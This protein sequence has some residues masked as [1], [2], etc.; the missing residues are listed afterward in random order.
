LTTWDSGFKHANIVL[1]GGALTAT[2]VGGVPQLVRSTTSKS[3]GKVWVEIT[4]STIR[5]DMAVGLCNGTETTAPSAG[6]GGD[7]NSYGFYPVTPPQASYVALTSLNGGTFSSGSSEHVFL[8]IDFG[9]SPPQVWV[10]TETMRAVGNTYNNSTTADPA[11]AT[12][13]QALTGINAGPYF[14]AF[15]DEDGGAQ[16]VA[17]FGATTPAHAIPSGFSAWDPLAPSV[18]T[19]GGTSSGAGIGSGAVA[20]IGTGGGQGSGAGLSVSAGIIYSTGTGGGT[21]TGQALS[22]R[23]SATVG[24][25]G[26]HATGTAFSIVQIGIP[27]YSVVPGSS[28]PGA[29]LVTA[30][31]T[32]RN[33]VRPQTWNASIRAGDDFKVALTVMSDDATPAAVGASTSALG[34]W[35]SDGGWSNGWSFPHSARQ[36]VS[37]W[38]VYGQT[39]RI[40]FALP[41]TE[42]AKLACGRYCLGITVSLPDGSWVV[43]EGMLQ[44]R[45]RWL[46]SLGH[47][48]NSA[49]VAAL[50][51]GQVN[52]QPVDIN[53]FFLLSPDFA[54]A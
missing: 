20:S 33:A 28:G 26:G 24:T 10:T 9:L 5:N 29:Y 41:G 36:V 48:V 3:A 27:G 23:V 13:G 14:L 40:N 49:D 2:S 12:G 25:G 47:V 35:G 7:A 38:V 8:A 50:T 32:P 22:T 6:I 42:T 15:N 16:V 21:A 43:L 44:V 46:T 17:N 11:T 39:G 18:G 30:Q 51:A 4:L 19:G 1:T 34:L 37:G 53:G 45:D 31:R 52:F 54:E